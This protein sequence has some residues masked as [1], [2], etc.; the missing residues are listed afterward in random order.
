VVG[1]V[2][3]LRMCIMLILDR[4][5]SGSRSREIIPADRAARVTKPGTRPW[6]IHGSHGGAAERK[7]LIRTFLSWA[8]FLPIL[9]VLAVVSGIIHTGPA[10][11]NTP[12]VPDM[13]GTLTFTTD[14]SSGVSIIGTDYN[15]IVTM[16]RVYGLTVP[17]NPG[18]G[19]PGI[20][21]A[22]GSG[23]NSSIN[24]GEA[25]TPGNILI[26]V[27]NTHGISAYS[28]G[29]NGSD[30]QNATPSTGSTPG[31]DGTKAG[32]VTVNTTENINSHTGITTA[33]QN[34]IGILAVSQ[35][36]NGGKGGRRQSRLRPQ[37]RGQR[38]LRRRG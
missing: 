19:N 13:N 2:I 12:P 21:L 17:I 5:F 26:N 24:S 32:N 34:A 18:V 30:G 22:N 33:G 35:G 36:G 38:W 6:E 7:T 20:S 9:P 4:L 15:P 8:L 23:L 16:L 3:V 31:G 1:Q 10:T 29:S 14:Q 37:S 28:H 27:T 11:A 25:T